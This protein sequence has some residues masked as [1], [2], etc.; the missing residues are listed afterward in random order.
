MGLIWQSSRDRECFDLS[1]RSFSGSESLDVDGTK[2]DHEGSNRALNFGPVGYF[3]MRVLVRPDQNQIRTKIFVTV[4][5]QSHL[6]F[7]LRRRRR[8]LL[9]LD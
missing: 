1:T 8:L 9:P 2:S 7:L 4:C 5:T 3:R 6:K